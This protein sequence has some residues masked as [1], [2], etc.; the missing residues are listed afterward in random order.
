M[1]NIYFNQL[2]RINSEL[3]NIPLTDE[4]ISNVLTFYNH[5]RKLEYY[6]RKEG[7]LQLVEYFERT[8]EFYGKEYMRYLQNWYWMELILD[9]L[10]NWDS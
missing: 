4:I 3:E 1:N 8:E 10:K 9:S 5:L 6:V 2:E 7:L